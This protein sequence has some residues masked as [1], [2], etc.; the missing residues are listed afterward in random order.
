[1]E[2]FRIKKDIP[3]MRHA[4]IFNVISAV[5]FLAAVFF[6]VHK[7]L[8]L[9]VEFKGG[10]LMEVKYPK[11]ANLEGI[12]G[13]LIAMGY[14]EPGVTSFDTAR[15][16]MIRLPVENGV[17]AA[18]TSQ[19]V[20]ESLCKAEQG[21]TKAIDT[22]TEKG[23]HVLKS[24]CMDTAGNEAVVLQKVEFV[25][26][27][28][29]EELAQNGL[30]ALVVVII[31]VM[32]YLAIRFEWKYAVS[33]IIANLHDVVIILGF[34]AFFEWEFSLTV[35]AA[36]LAVLG[37]SVNE[38]VVIFDRIREN[39]RKQRKASV[40]EVID[41][42]ITSTI[43]RTI[44]T[45]GSTQM[46]VLSMLVFGGQTLHHFALALTIGICF[47]IYSSVFVAASIAMWLG[48]KREDLIKPVKE[49]DETDG[50]VV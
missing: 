9:S 41:N 50:A 15:D 12:R 25:G 29:G 3:F 27:Q 32:I 37:Y 23:E 22:V 40:H 16:V 46:M 26:P 8:H 7:G 21:A 2:F 19:R 38:S 24:A 5:T 28:V 34:F 14:E 33:A 31:G 1:M 44:I 48:V 39:F 10:T 11:A 6:L 13:T 42:A 36:I 17:S 4:L 20:F 18:N 43:S 47:G 35:L 45:H 49:K 30:N